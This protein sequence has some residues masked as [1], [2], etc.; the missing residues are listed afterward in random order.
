M[1]IEDKTESN[2][3]KKTFHIPKSIIKEL[4]QTGKK[5]YR[6]VNSELIIAVEYYLSEWKH[7][8]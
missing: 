8:H 7:K 2:M 3:V 4:E 6:S 1:N 5:N